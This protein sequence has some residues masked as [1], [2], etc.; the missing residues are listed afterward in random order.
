MWDSRFCV[1]GGTAGRFDYELSETVTTQRWL[2]CLYHW[3]LAA[4]VSCP[5]GDCWE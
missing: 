3:L 4:P 2:R 5:D 1:P